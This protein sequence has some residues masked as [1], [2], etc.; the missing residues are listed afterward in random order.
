LWIF[1]ETRKEKEIT[2]F[3]HHQGNIKQKEKGAK[4]KT[5]NTKNRK[6]P[7]SLVMV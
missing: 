4:Q 1:R 6:E 5:K 2:E 3:W 7:S